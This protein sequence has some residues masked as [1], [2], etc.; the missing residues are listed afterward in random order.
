MASPGNSPGAFSNSFLTEL[1]LPA[2]WSA[3]DIGRPLTRIR[4]NL[5]CPNLEQL[6]AEVIEKMGPLEHEVHIGARDAPIEL[7]LLVFVH[8]DSSFEAKS[9]SRMGT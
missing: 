1:Q 8:A 9:R 7:G 5:D 3:S 6:L 4:N 2:V